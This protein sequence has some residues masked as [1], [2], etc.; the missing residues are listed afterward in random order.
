MFKF[1]TKIAKNRNN[2]YEI[3]LYLCIYI[4]CRKAKEHRKIY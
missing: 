2:T 3:I 4:S 1:L